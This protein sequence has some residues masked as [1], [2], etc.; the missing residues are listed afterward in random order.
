MNVK[1]LFGYAVAV[2]LL[3]TGFASCTK[4]D[5]KDDPNTDRPTVT[6]RYSVEVTETTQN[7]VKAE[8]TTTGTETDTWYAF[9]T[10]DLDTRADQVIE[11][12]VAGLDDIESV[13]KSGDAEV[14]FT[15]LAAGTS[16]RII[17][18][19]LAADGTVS[20]KSDEAEFKTSRDPNAWAEN[21]DWKVEY[22]GRDSYETSAGTTKY[23][24]LIN[25]T[26]SNDNTDYYYID[27][28]SKS[29]FENVYKGSIAEFAKSTIENLNALIEENNELYPDYPVTITDIVYYGSGSIIMGP[30]T[31]EEQ[32]V[33]LVGIEPS[34]ITGEGSGLYAMSEAFTPDVEEASEAYNKWL[35]SWT[36]S[37]YSDAAGTTACT[38]TIKIEANI[39]N[40]DYTI[41]GWQDDLMLNNDGS[42]IT[43]SPATFDEGS[44][45]LY[46]NSDSNLGQIDTGNYGI[47]TLEFLGFADGASFGYPGENVNIG[48]DYTIAIASMDADGKV[49]VEA[50]TIPLMSG[51]SVKLAGMQF[52]AAVTGGT[53]YWEAPAPRFDA[54]NF[55]MTRSEGSSSSSASS[56]SARSLVKKSAKTAEARTYIPMSLTYKVR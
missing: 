50:Q 35:G 2:S 39:P 55:T 24:D 20:G 11:A 14:E 9:V 37:G 3:A 48:G 29:D 54:G 31:D 51:E 52:Y 10:M 19:G 45:A 18:T 40:Y 49:T 25:V 46:I 47:G 15:G 6:V 38:N 42:Y 28:V 7:S 12:T 13:L 30:L 44:G 53:L 56:V 21:P 32:Y 1:C 8:V 22:V 16:Y 17:V 4:D 26:V 34:G 23:G 5:Q 41:Y 27:A 33:V 43:G 36:V